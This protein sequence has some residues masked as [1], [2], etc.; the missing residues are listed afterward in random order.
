MNIIEFKIPNQIQEILSI[1]TTNNVSYYLFGGSVRDV[2][3]QKEPNDYDF[4]VTGIDRDELCKILDK[5][6]IPNYTVSVRKQVQGLCINGIYCE[7]ACCKEKVDLMKY[8]KELDFTCNQIILDVENGA[9]V[10]IFN[11]CKDI[12]Q[13]KVRTI[14]PP[15]ECF[16][17]Y[18][19]NMIRASYIAMNTGFCIDGACVKA[20]R[21]CPKSAFEIKYRLVS[22]T[23]FNNILSNEHCEEGMK[24][25]A[26]TGILE[27]EFPKLYQKVINNNLNY[28]EIRYINQSI[29]DLA[30]DDVRVDYKTALLFM[31]V[32][33]D[34]S[35]SITKFRFYDANNKRTVKL[36]K[37]GVQYYNLL[38]TVCIDEINQQIKEKKVKPEVRKE[39]LKLIVE[40]RA[41]KERFKKEKDSV[42]VFR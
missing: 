25:L 26:K 31:D 33:A 32:F 20:I 37:Y 14:L 2:F 9:V 13:K 21:N 6:N 15:E 12:E 30:Y 10:D 7:F 11:G 18:P 19:F 24:W 29:Q 39:I 3:T 36:L 8:I 5:N 42:H 4:V 1:L 41:I 28:D 27:K 23:I 22:T 35:E 17:L 38:D 16:E 34:D 40:L